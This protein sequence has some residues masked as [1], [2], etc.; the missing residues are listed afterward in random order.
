MSE[1]TTTTA[2]DSDVSAM[3]S[4]QFILLLIIEVFAGVWI[5]V[6]LVYFGRNYHRIFSKN[7]RDHG[8][9]LLT[10]LSFLYITL[11]LPFTINSFRL[12]YDQPRSETFCKYWYW[13]DYS[14]IVSSSFL[15]AIISI[16][17]HILIF[18]AACFNRPR[19]RFLLHYIPLILCLLCPT[20]GYFILL[21][22]Y[23]C[24]NSSDEYLVYCPSPCYSW[25]R[26][27]YHI[28]WILDTIVP[29]GGIIISNLVLIFRVIR[30]LRKLRGK[31]SLM[32]KRQRKLTIELL[33]IS[34]LYALGWGPSTVV[35][36]IQDLFVPDIF[37]RVPT[38][39]Y[40]YY[41]SYFVCPLQPFLYLIMSSEIM[42]F[43]KQGIQRL[44]TWNIVAPESVNRRVY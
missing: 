22:L 15:T 40:T 34:S 3:E 11:D 20:I 39:S 6:I 14:I 31:R 19:C 18:N 29:V 43:I 37:E 16:Q 10:V 42:A 7:L 21:Y 2:V 32:L 27:L 17:R 9:F 5:L 25:N 30:S 13:I 26:I 36:V 44:F 23:P 35:G 28:D 8:F 41:M 24:Q 38:L 12:G 1:N 4:V 33:V